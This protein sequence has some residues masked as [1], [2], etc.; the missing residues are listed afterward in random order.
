MSSAVWELQKALHAGLLANAALVDAIGGP[1][2]WDHVPRGAVFPYVTIGA[3]TNLDWS[4]GTDT[5]CEHILTVHVWSTTPGRKEAETIANAIRQTLHDQPLTLAGY[6]LVNFRHEL[7]ET[8]RTAETE[9][10]HAIVR[11][12]AV[13]EPTA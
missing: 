11:F 9:L 2:V 1:R 5:G 3:S 7:T 8:R 12:R 6:R 13:T 10:Y 4:T